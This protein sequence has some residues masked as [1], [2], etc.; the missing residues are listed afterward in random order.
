VSTVE[1][2]VRVIHKEGG[3][4]VFVVL[5]S[6]MGDVVQGLPLIAALPFA[7]V[8]GLA[9]SSVHGHRG[10]FSCRVWGGR[11]VLVSEGRLHYYE[12]HPWENVVRP[13]Q[14]A[15]GLGIKKAILTNA[16]GGIRDDLAPGTLMPLREHLEWNRPYPWRQ[17]AALS[18]YSR[19]GLDLVADLGGVV[20]PGTYAS[21]QG[22]NYETPAEI[23][24][25]RSQGADAVGMSTTREARAGSD[26][27]MEVIALSLVTN[28][29]AGLSAGTLDHEE[30]LAVGRQAADRL[31]HLIESLLRRF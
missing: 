6:G 28:R 23:R 30:V 22:P 21:V 8:P 27:G 5:G 10:Q 1:E 20:E 31:G 29:A 17:P 4:E 7:A 18:P 14:F 19:R 24:A 12:G 13:I 9:R 26:A 2:F 25:L 11:P 15:G 16:A 3:L